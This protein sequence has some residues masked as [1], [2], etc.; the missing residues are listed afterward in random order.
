MF[1]HAA[2][3][4]SI[5]NSM[6]KLWCTK[7]RVFSWI[8]WPEHNSENW[9]CSKLGKSPKTSGCCAENI[10]CDVMRCCVNGSN[11]SF[12]RSFQLRQSDARYFLISSLIIFEVLSSG[13]S[14][15]EDWRVSAFVKTDNFHSIQCALLPDTLTLNTSLV[16]QKKT[17]FLVWTSFKSYTG[18]TRSSGLCKCRKGTRLRW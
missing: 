6:Q 17:G 9:I 3:R 16:R 14:S 4:A 12:D 11:F 18:G 2:W 15:T 10:S 5:W 8:Y 7:L 1:Q 13:L